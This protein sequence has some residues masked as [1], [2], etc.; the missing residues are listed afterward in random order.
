MIPFENSAV[1]LQCIVVSGEVIWQFSPACATAIEVP[2]FLKKEEGTNVGS[3]VV[4]DG[5]GVG[6]GKSSYLP[7]LKAI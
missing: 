1:Q 3:V 2:C 6:G 4:G 7:S 5:D